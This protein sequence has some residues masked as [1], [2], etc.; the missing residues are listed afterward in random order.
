MT[1]GK[2]KSKKISSFCLHIIIITIDDCCNKM[3]RSQASSPSHHS[4]LDIEASSLMGGGG[5]GVVSGSI[6]EHNGNPFDLLVNRSRSK[7]IFT[8][9]MSRNTGICSESSKNYIMIAMALL[10]LIIGE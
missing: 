2:K 10:I 9:W 4:S 1:V 5:A 7:I 8:T 6:K 3:V